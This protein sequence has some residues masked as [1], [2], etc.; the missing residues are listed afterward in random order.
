MHVRHI[1]V[2][3]LLVATVGLSGCAS[4]EEAAD[5]PTPTVT[6]SGTTSTGASTSPTSEAPT[7]APNTIEIT[8]EGD[9][10][11]PSGKRV[12]VPVNEPITLRVTADAPGEI[13]LH[14][15]PEQEVAYQAG[16]H[17]YVVTFDR[18]GK[19]E[20]ESHDL[21]KVIVQLQVS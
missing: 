11:D 6:P 9:T 7:E 20:V 14:S 21:E 16:T 1:A 13:H 15:T 12:D 19:V 2:T 18:P 5:E 10:V 4:K 17:D 8:I 3:A